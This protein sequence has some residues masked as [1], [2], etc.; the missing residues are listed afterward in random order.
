MHVSPFK[1]E[2]CR[3]SLFLQAGPCHPE[4]WLL[5]F[6]QSLFVHSSGKVFSAGRWCDHLVSTRL[7]LARQIVN[8]GD[9]SMSSSH[10]CCSEPGEPGLMALPK[11]ICFALTVGCE[12]GTLQLQHFSTWTQPDVSIPSRSCLNCTESPRELPWCRGRGWAAYQPII[13]S[14]P[15][16]PCRRCE[17]WPERCSEI[18]H[19]GPMGDRGQKWLRWGEQG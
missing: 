6:V 17:K 3:L 18:V 4:D 7:W 8:S 5:G 11:H 15:G 13:I 19:F 14:G 2:G 1:A 9:P 16:S 10:P 12:S